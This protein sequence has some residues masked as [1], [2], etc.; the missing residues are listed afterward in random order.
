MG[1]F[2]VVFKKSTPP[3]KI[4]Q[5]IKKVEA[6]GGKITH[7]YDSV[8]LGYAAEIPDSLLASVKGTAEIDYIEADGEV[9]AYA[10][11]LL[12]KK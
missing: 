11:G 3:S 2:I 10:A 9:S 5:S 12:K 6:D 8:L 4:D 7:R 1:R